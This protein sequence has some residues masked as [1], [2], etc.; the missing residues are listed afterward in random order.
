MAEDVDKQLRRIQGLA[1]KLE[2]NHSQVDEMMLLMKADGLAA[3]RYG[4]FSSNNIPDPTSQAAFSS[5]RVVDADGYG[6]EVIVWRDHRPEA[7]REG[8]QA[9]IRAAELAL[10]AADTIRQRYM[11]AN[12]EIR[13]RLDPTEFCHIHWA[14]HLYEGHR[15]TKGNLCTT[16]AKFY[17]EHK[18]EPTATEADY[19]HRH[20]RWPHRLVD[21]KE[22]R[23][24]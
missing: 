11:S 21:P 15:R 2:A 1:S 13:N 22:R 10:D 24:V 3:M 8:Y 23:A 14:L 9:A 6:K 5:R 16:C 4:Q 17:D 7:D 19:Y 18:R 12:L 20:G